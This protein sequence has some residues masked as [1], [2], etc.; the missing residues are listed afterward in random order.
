M[1]LYYN[2]NNSGHGSPG[3]SRHMM[4]LYPHVYE[5]HHQRRRISMDEL[6]DRRAKIQ[7]Q[8][9][10]LYQQNQRRRFTSSNISVVQA[11]GSGTQTPFLLSAND[12]PYQNSRSYQD[13][14]R[15]SSGNRSM[16]GLSGSSAA[17]IIQASAAAKEAKAQAKAER[18][19]SLHHLLGFGGNKP[20]KP[21]L[22]IPQQRRKKKARQRSK[23]EVTLDRIRFR[24]GQ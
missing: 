9:C 10:Q 24:R 1:S 6:N 14:R 4:Y 13:V 11:P 8:H 20:D 18:R 2:H 7:S 23:S 15:L 17:L 16:C 5:P 3:N 22:T 19:S 12:Y 21:E